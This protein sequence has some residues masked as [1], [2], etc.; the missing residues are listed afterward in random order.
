MITLEI[1]TS[2]DKDEEQMFLTNLLKAIDDA[3][4]QT[5]FKLKAPDQGRFVRSVGIGTK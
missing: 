5:R 4:H 3:E 2:L 1:K